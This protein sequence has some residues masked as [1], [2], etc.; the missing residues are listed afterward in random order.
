M[1]VRLA[2]LLEALEALAPLRY[3]GDWDNV[4]L[5]VEPPESRTPVSRVLLTI[6]LTEA[7]FDEALERGADLIVA[8]HPPIFRGWKRLR[9]GDSRQRTIMRAIRA[10]VPV[11]SPHTALD[12]APNGVDDWLAEALGPAAA[13]AAIDPSPEDGL[14]GR[15]IG[16]GRV[17]TLAQPVALA[18]LID[19]VKAHLELP[20][21]R[22]AA[23]AD[24]LSGQRLVGRVAVCPGSGGALFEA[25]HEPDLYLT[26]EMRH[27]DVLGKVAA[28]ASVVLTEHTNCERGYLP[29]FAERL[30]A[31]AAVEVLVSVC[32]HDPLAVH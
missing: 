18:E 22:L 27:H 4:G 15:V 14:G 8:Y 11:Y 20:H 28:G 7:V 29:R 1:A 12:A 32:D 16:H 6:D 25:L 24:L 31:A 23:A 26:G 17:V 9:L 30:A 10:G 21:V 5:L 19:R 13:C 3:A 2:E